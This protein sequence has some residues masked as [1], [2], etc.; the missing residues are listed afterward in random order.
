MADNTVSTGKAAKI[1]GVTADTVLKW[2]KKGAI[3]AVRTPGGHYRIKTDSLS[4]YIAE[5]DLVTPRVHD[6]A[7]GKS[8]FCWEYH[9][10]NGD[11]RQDC[12]NCMVFKA[13]AERC[14]LLAG[15]GE[16]VER[17][18][19]SCAENCFNCEFYKYINKLVF[20]VLIITD[21]EELKNVILKGMSSLYYPVFSCC[22]YETA[23]VI[24]DFHPDYI[25]IDDSMEKS[26][27]EELTTYLID[28]PRI[29]GAQIILAVESE[30]AK[31]NPPTGVCAF[32][33]LPF[34]ARD[35]EK[36]F[37]DLHLKLI[38]PKN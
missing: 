31:K 30:G 34:A 9:A 17:G 36:C 22:G 2:I 21:R 6:G 7:A 33:D 8:S 5:H 24:H 25:V 11:L 3:S 32:I 26:K 38:G 27:T 10:Q 14:Y 15:K 29:H 23:T 28:D 12:R 16:I 37:N 19:I 35:L 4:P 18:A 13:K 1:C 20:N